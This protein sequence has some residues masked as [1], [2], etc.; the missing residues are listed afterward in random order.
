METREKLAAPFDKTFE[1]NG[2]TYI[3]G[4]QV[5]TRLNE[6]LGW[7][8]WSFQIKMHGYDQESDEIWVLG[9]LTALGVTKEQFGSQKHNRTKGD[10]AI[11]DYGFDLKGAATD[12]M[13]KCAS[14]IG[15]GLYLS[16]KSGGA[17]MPIRPPIQNTPA[18]EKKGF[19]AVMEELGFNRD[20]VTAESQRMFNNK[21]PRQLT[22]EEMKSLQLS[23]EEKAKKVAV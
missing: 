18:P 6:V 16:E 22:K 15:V 12:A 5:T 20:T 7:D 3:T 23:L 11:I 8:G 4:E 9:E 2:Q 1:K 14:L 10:R 21:E 13:K 19:F 17:P